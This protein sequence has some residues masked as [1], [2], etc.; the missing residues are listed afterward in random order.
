MNVSKGLRGPDYCLLQLRNGLG[1]EEC[2]GRNFH[3][4][5]EMDRDGRVWSYILDRENCFHQSTV[6]DKQS[7]TV[8][9]CDCFLCSHSQISG[10]SLNVPFQFGEDLPEVCTGCTVCKAL[11]TQSDL[12]QQV[13]VLFK[14]LWRSKN[15][16]G[17]VAKSGEEMTHN[18]LTTYCNQKNLSVLKN[19]QKHYKASDMYQALT[20]WFFSTFCE[21]LSQFVNFFCKDLT[22]FN[23]H[24]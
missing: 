9:C 18:V 1:R 23:K 3:Q 20:A 17:S 21:L 13:C 4:R 11:A 2:K 5:I 6:A 22:L 16:N 8:L 19:A 7:G 14:N 24:C 15:E 12:V 10:M